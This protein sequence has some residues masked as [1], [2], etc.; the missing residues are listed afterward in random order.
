MS[1]FLFVCQSVGLSGS[2]FSS[3]GSRRAAWSH[4]LQKEAYLPVHEKITHA[5]YTL[6]LNSSVRKQNARGGS[7]LYTALYNNALIYYINAMGYH[8]PVE[9]KPVLPA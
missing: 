7:S 9:E 6:D 4:F 5:A 2:S 8:V 1:V 3:T